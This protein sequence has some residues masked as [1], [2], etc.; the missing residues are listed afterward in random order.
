MVATLLFPHCYALLVEK[1]RIRHRLKAPLYHFSSI[2]SIKCS[3]SLPEKLVPKCQKFL[4]AR[5]EQSQL[6]RTVVWLKDCISKGV[7]THLMKLNLPCKNRQFVHLLTFYFSFTKD[8]TKLVWQAAASCDA[9]LLVLMPLHN[10][11]SRVQTRLTDPFLTEGVQQKLQ[12][13]T[14]K[15]SY[16]KTVV[17]ALGAFLLSPILL[18]HRR[19]V[20]MS[21]SA[22][23]A[24]TTEWL[25]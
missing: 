16:E 13:V 4:S 19:P 5:S 6:H 20:A 8:K 15:V 21:Q 24:I 25:A 3:F 1:H 11:L 14:S 12:D 10:F 2:N 9:C 18:A 22:Q 23:A 7:F 17:S